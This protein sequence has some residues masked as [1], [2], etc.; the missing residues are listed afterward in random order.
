MI[1][2]EPDCRQS[3]EIYPHKMN[4]TFKVKQPALRFRLSE[5]IAIVDR[6]RKT[7]SQPRNKNKTQPIEMN[8]IFGVFMEA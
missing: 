4:H 8:S 5:M 3:K 6:T 2:L 1:V 7:I